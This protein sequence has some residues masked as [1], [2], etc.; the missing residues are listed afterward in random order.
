MNTDTDTAPTPPTLA[1]RCA[2]LAAVQVPD[3]YTAKPSLD[4]YAG[5]SRAGSVYRSG[6]DWQAISTGQNWRIDTVD[7]QTAQEA[8]ERLI[9]HHA[10]K[11]AD[12]ELEAEVRAEI[13]RRRAEPQS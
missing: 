7:G 1:E 13:L 12:A 11:K 10:A 5:A 8:V 2:E 6:S 3:G 4:V 9:A